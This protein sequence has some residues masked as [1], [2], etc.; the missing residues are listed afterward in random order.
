MGQCCGLIRNSGSHV[1]ITMSQY[2]IYPHWLRQ[3]CDKQF[4]SK[5]PFVE[6]TELSF[7]VS[8]FHG[9]SI[10]IWTQTQTSNSIWLCKYICKHRCSYADVTLPSYIWNST[11]KRYPRHHIHEYTSM[12]IPYYLSS[13]RFVLTNCIYDLYSS[14]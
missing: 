6:L 1:V 7:G 13:D 11:E 10:K 9:E 8:S 12:D 3:Y 5:R 14:L 4:E 2:I